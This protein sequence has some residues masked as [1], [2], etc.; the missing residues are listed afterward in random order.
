[1]FAMNGIMAK[2][3]HKSHLF[4]VS[5]FCYLTSSTKV[6]IFLLNFPVSVGVVLSGLSELVYY[7]ESVLM[8]GHLK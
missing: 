8:L 4:H 3:F 7:K 2:K 6:L 1:M 5:G